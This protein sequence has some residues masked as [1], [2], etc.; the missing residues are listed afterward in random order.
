MSFARFDMRG[1]GFTTPLPWDTFYRATYIDDESFGGGS[2]G[3]MF[4]K[5]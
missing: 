2:C 3:A 5:G 1:G 4:D